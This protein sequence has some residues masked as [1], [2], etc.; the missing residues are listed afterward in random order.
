M[1]C[2]PGLFPGVVSGPIWRPWAFAWSVFCFSFLF[3]ADPAALRRLCV[4]S[5]SP[6]HLSGAHS[7]VGK[8]AACMMPQNAQGTDTANERPD[9]GA[10][11]RTMSHDQGG[12]QRNKRRTKR[13]ETNERP[14]NDTAPGRWSRRDD[15]A[16]GA[17]PSKQRAEGEHAAAAAAAAC[18]GRRCKSNDARDDEA[19]RAC[20]G[21]ICSICV[22]CSE[23]PRANRTSRKRKQSGAPVAVAR[24][25]VLS[26]RGMLLFTRVGS[27]AVCCHAC[28]A[29]RSSNRSAPSRTLVQWPSTPT[30]KGKQGK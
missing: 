14:A 5:L 2:W 27:L 23:G 21:G 6:V 29:A 17:S 26:W 18:T 7:A 9:S 25:I 15:V 28:L 24:L 13:T 12:R 20:S 22:T 3:R 16:Y 8:W 4:S 30:R 1:V 11:G 10:R 19:V